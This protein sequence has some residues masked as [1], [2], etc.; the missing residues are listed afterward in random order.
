MSKQIGSSSEVD[1]G[2]NIADLSAMV[3]WL[4]VLFDERWLYPTSRAAILLQMMLLVERMGRP[5]W[6]RMQYLGI[7]SGFFDDTPCERSRR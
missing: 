2:D 4:S 7:R 3:C 1:F 6:N 5:I